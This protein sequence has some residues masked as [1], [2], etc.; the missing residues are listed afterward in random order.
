MILILAPPGDSH[1]RAVAHELRT[2]FH[3]SAIIWD[4]GAL[5]FDDTLSLELANDRVGARVNGTLGARDL[6]GLRSIWVRRPMTYR[7]DSAVTDPAVRTFCWRECEAWF[8]GTL[9]SLG[10]PLIN[11]PTAQTAARKPRQLAVARSVGLDIPRTLISNDPAE[12]TRFWEAL[13][14]DC[15]YKVL[16]AAPTGM[17]ET[18]LLTATD[19]HDL[20]TLKHAPIIVQERIDKGADIRVNVFGQDV[21]AAAVTTNVSA[22]E[23]DWRLDLSARWHAHDLPDDLR[24]RLIRLLRTLGLQYGCIDLRQRSDGTYVFLE[25]NPSGQF[26]F[27][28]LD[29]GQPL[30]QS[31]ARLLMY[32]GAE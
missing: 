18:R 2:T 20:D 25:V 26:L 4:N 19:L 7:I 27:V 15:I 8:R 32:P 23:L 12:I 16:T 1:A 6:M 29:T 24:S 28:E 17:A 31:L 21:F 14:R 22:A 9:D 3:A 11:D 30:S 5:P 13:E 10:V